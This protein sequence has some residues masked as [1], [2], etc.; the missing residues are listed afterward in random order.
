VQVGELAPAHSLEV[1]HCSHL[2]ITKYRRRNE[3]WQPTR[4]PCV[5]RY[6]NNLNGQTKLRDARVRGVQPAPTDSRSAG[7]AGSRCDRSDM[8]SGRNARKGVDPVR[9]T[10]AD[11]PPHN[12]RCDPTI[13]RR[14][15]YFRRIDFKCLSISRRGCVLLT[16]RWS[17]QSYDDCV[18]SDQA[19]VFHF[20]SHRAGR[21]CMRRLFAD[22][23]VR[24]A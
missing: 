16:Q 10:I 22:R 19:L 15:S 3:R 13:A 6:D 2:T 14:H 8:Q 24:L 5:S 11:L 9:L 1:H 4:K 18:L 12:R 20:S 23:V 7:T 17:A 21:N